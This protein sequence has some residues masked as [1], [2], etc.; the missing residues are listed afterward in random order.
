[1]GLWFMVEP[2]ADSL[3]EGYR[4]WA[5]RYVSRKLRTR[6]SWTIAVSGAFVGCFLAFQD[7]FRETEAIKADIEVAHGERDEAR[8]Q[9]DISTSPVQQGT[10]DRLSGDLIAARGAIDSLKKENDDLH[11]RLSELNKGIPPKYPLTDPERERL[12][13][14]LCGIPKEQ[15]FAV[16]L[17]WPQLNGTHGYADDLMGAFKDCQWDASVRMAAL[18]NGHGLVFA[19]SKKDMDDKKPPPSNAIKLMALFG[20]AQVPWAIGGL[21]NVPEGTFAFI[22]GEPTPPPK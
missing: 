9:R 10:I 22:V 4:H 7:Q 8:R 12:R 5:D 16:E 13:V 3:W 18:T 11:A 21:D 1:M 17:F 20:A 19:L 15:R 14:V 2:L 6:V